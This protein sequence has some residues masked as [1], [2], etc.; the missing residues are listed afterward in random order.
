MII[1]KVFP[2]CTPNT[3]HK[4]I[5]LLTSVSFRLELLSTQSHSHR[6]WCVFHAL[7]LFLCLCLPQ[8]DALPF[9]VLWFGNQK[10]WKFIEVLSLSLIPT[11][12]RNE[13]KWKPP[14]TKNFLLLCTHFE[15]F[16]TS[17]TLF[18]ALTLYLSLVSKHIPNTEFNMHNFQYAPF[19]V[20]SPKIANAVV[21]SVY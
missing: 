20:L 7:Y 10:L 13:R 9:K 16:S 11:P 6:L 19:G 14:Q 12:L 18:F 3:Q 15:H 8:S 4:P 21:D 1:F 17:G 5:H 2:M